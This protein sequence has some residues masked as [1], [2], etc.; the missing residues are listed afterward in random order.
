MF[1]RVDGLRLAYEVD[2]E[3]PPICLLHGWGG[4][5]R[6]LWPIHQRLARSY[7][8]FSLD[9]PGFGRSAIPPFTWGVGDYANCVR[10]WIEELGISKPVIVGH[11]HGGRVAI[12][13]AAGRPDVARALVL[14]DAAGIR[15]KHGAGYHLKV[16]TAKTGRKV[17][18]API[19]NARRRALEGRLYRLL[20]ASDYAEAGPLRQIFVRIVNEDLRPLLSRIQNP[21][22]L[23]WGERDDAT[24]LSDA[25][26]M[27]REIPGARLVVL[28]GAGHFAYL[29]QPDEFV[30]QVDS[31][32]NNASLVGSR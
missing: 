5:A 11:S 22:L 29:E 20:G 17:L 15:P 28:P 32:I 14:T 16:F 23:I 19:F 27:E 30:R 8:V 21:T 31:F 24:P 12:S 25:K 10:G 7:R 18:S 1:T 4:E 3:G 2:G 9:F 13:L 26:I 6:S